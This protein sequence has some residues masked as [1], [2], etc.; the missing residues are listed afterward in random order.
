MNQDPDNSLQW[1]CNGRIFA[2]SVQYQAGIEIYYQADVSF[3]DN[4]Q[5]KYAL[6]LAYLKSKEYEKSIEYFTLALHLKP[7]YLL[8]KVRRAIAYDFNEQTELANAEFEAILSSKALDNEDYRA[9]GIA[10]FCYYETSRSYEALPY[11]DKALEFVSDDYQS[12]LDKG[13]VLESL[14]RHKEA[15]D[16][17]NKILKADKD[18]V[19]LINIIGYFHYEAKRYREASEVFEKSWRVEPYNSDIWYKQGMCLFH[20][21]QLDA[22][23]FC[24]DKALN[25]GVDDSCV[26]EEISKIKTR[27]G[28]SDRQIK[29]HNIKT[30]LSVFVEDLHLSKVIQF[31]NKD[32]TEKINILLESGFK[33]FGLQMYKTLNLTYAIHRSLRLKKYNIAEKLD[34][35]I[36]LK[37]ISNFY[38]GSLTGNASGNLSLS[39]WGYNYFLELITSVNAG[40]DWDITNLKL[41]INK[42]KIEDTISFLTSVHDLKLCTSYSILETITH[43]GISLSYFERTKRQR[44][45]DIKQAI[46]HSNLALKSCLNYPFLYAII[47]EHLGQIYI[48]QIAENKKENIEQAIIHF[49]KALETI[50]QYN[51]I[52]KWTEIKLKLGNIYLLERIEGSKQENVEQAIIHFSHALEANQKNDAPIQCAEIKIVL[53]EIYFKHRIKGDKSNNIKT[54]IDYYNSVLETYNKQQYPSQW[55]STLIKISDIY[56]SRSSSQIAERKNNLNIAIDYLSHA[57]DVYTDN[58]DAYNCAIVNYKIGNIYRYRLEFSTKKNYINQ[59]ESI[60][61]YKKSL[62]VFSLDNFP[63]FWVRIQ[64]NIGICYLNVNLFDYGRDYKLNDEKS[65]IHFKNAFNKLSEDFTKN[66]EVDKEENLHIWIEVANYLSSCYLR[67]TAEDE[68]ENK[69][70]VN[71]IYKK[72][73]S[74]L[75][76]DRNSEK[77]AIEIA[78][79]QTKLARF[80]IEQDTEKNI[81]RAIGLLN[82][83]LIAVDENIHPIIW[84]ETKHRLGQAYCNRVVGN[85]R[86]NKIT[87]IS[88]YKSALNLIDNEINI[89]HSKSYL[90]LISDLGKVYFSLEKWQLSIDAYS[91]IIKECEWLIDVIEDREFKHQLYL[92]ADVIRAYKDTINACIHLNKLD[93]SL[94]YIE[95]NKAKILVNLLSLR[96]IYPKGNVSQKVLDRLDYLRDCIIREEYNLVQPDKSSISRENILNLQKALENFI[97]KEIKPIDPSFK[98]SHR[99]E[100]ITFEEIKKSLPCEKSVLVEWYLADDNTLFAF[101]VA[102]K[103]EQPLLISYSNEECESLYKLFKHYL[104][105]YLDDYSNWNLQLNYLFAEI[106]TNLKLTTIID[107]I[108]KFVPDCNRLILVPHRWLHL[109]P[110]HALP[111]GNNK[112]LLD[113][114]SQGVSYAPSVQL[115]K[116]S[117]KQ[118]KPE[119]TNLFAVQNPTN[120]LNFTN[121]EVQ[122]I[123]SQFEPNDDVL[124]KDRAT[125]SALTQEKLAQTHIAHFSCHGYFNFENPELSALLL[126]DSKLEQEQQEEKGETRFLPSRE[127][128]SIDLEKC[129]TLGEIFGLDLRNCRLVTLSACETGLTDYKSLGDEYIGL[130]SGFLY[131]GS[132]SVV[133]SLWAVSDL[134]TTFLMIKFYQNLKSIDSVANRSQSGSTLVA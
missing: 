30:P 18:N 41:I 26:L 75:Y 37:N 66:Y 59:Q 133:S 17:Y 89:E 82:A 64:V 57:F 122:A 15:N 78:D 19:E 123:R 31:V 53:G 63:N 100:H 93:K 116:L 105:T 65:I 39:V 106:A 127:G 98:L 99:V 130:P 55:A 131:A 86:Q 46:H 42:K 33:K 23:F 71:K 95:Q 21:K 120:D 14:N 121:I 36:N 47:Q 92:D 128:G 40:L 25:I 85:D 9:K 24:F 27:I 12:L 101:L 16:I 76:L 8:A 28:Y 22:A 117:S 132:P 13:F 79:V 119:L 48:K 112:C 35:A 70:E 68:K 111:V 38:G 110:I 56:C 11:F 32:E 84:I 107:R 62:K 126:A 49:Y 4:P 113:L 88:H 94:E 96:N 50:T 69:R 67:R 109:L 115:L 20:L 5:I 52:V 97:H 58:K 77:Y 134:S 103:K 2:E 72:V 45:F 91:K 10:F 104:N 73:L 124:A 54:S 1:L 118:S 114:F 80:Y 87:A 3:P 29:Q 60:N 102:Q 83:N 7:D 6:G 125:K 51:C 81:E 90:D 108:R 44:S 129:L 34:L 43:L 61:H 74:F